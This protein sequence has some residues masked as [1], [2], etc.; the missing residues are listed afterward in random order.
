MGYWP[1]NYYSCADISITSN[2]LL[3][4]YT[5]NSTN[6]DSSTTAVAMTTGSETITTGSIVSTGSLVTTGNL[7]TTTENSSENSTAITTGELDTSNSS[8]IILSNLLLL[9]MLFTLI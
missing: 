7:E 1:N 4:L 9:I 8:K 6:G 3:P 5:Y 2:D